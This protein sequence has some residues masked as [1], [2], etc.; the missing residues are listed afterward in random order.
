MT[1]TTT[2]L[3]PIDAGIFLNRTIMLDPEGANAAALP[4]LEVLKNKIEHA[5][6]RAVFTWKEDPAPPYRDRVMQAAAENADVF[7]CVSAAG[8]LC[9]VGH[10]HRSVSGLAL[11]QQLQQ[12]F[13]AQDLPGFKE[14]AVLHSTHDTVLHTSMP[15]IELS[16][17]R[18][19]VQ[20]DPEAVAQ[21]IYAALREWLR[22]R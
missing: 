11:A 7:V 17:P 1:V 6:G 21:T 14:C 9:S 18:K 22:Q 3:Q 13:S 16:L 15:A 5:G 4:V 20:K 12:A 10:Y 2:V 19:F 8:R